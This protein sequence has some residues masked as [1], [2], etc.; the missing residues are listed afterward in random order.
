MGRNSLR[1]LHGCRSFTLNAD[2][3]NIGFWL[4]NITYTKVPA[5]IRGGTENSYCENPYNL[6]SK[7]KIKLNDT[8]IKKTVTE[9][10]IPAYDTV[11]FG[12]NVSGNGKL[13]LSWDKEG[14]EVLG[15]YDVSKLKGRV[16]FRITTDTYQKLYA[17]F[18]PV[19]SGIK[20]SDFYLF[21][22]FSLAGR[23]KDMG[24]AE[25]INNRKPV[26]FE[27]VPTVSGNSYDDVVAQNNTQNNVID[28]SDTSTSPSTGDT[29]I[30]V[31]IIVFTFVCS[32]ALLL[33]GKRKNAVNH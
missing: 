13:T 18:E 27:N 9:L 14:K 12:M 7:Q 29:G 24:Y 5:G 11:T 33:L 25:N 19:T 15:S 1:I 3:R 4:D 8:I 17:T 6:I 23:A 26:S 31:M 2:T 30:P 32:A 20:Y 16:G 28:G 10:E 21:K 22:S